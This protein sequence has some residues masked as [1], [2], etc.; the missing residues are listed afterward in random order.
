MSED[1][2]GTVTMV[3]K[4][5]ERDEIGSRKFPWT[6][7]R[8]PRIYWGWVVAFSSSIM[9]VVIYG[10]LYSFGIIMVDLMQEFESSATKTGKCHPVADERF[11]KGRGA[12]LHI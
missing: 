9:F 1:G 11:R 4:E 7:I 3:T 2:D 8:R 12:V 10:F 6:M 5:K